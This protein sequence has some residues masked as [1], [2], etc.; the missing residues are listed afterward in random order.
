LIQVKL[1]R[2]I[3]TRTFQPLGST[4]TLNFKGK[5]V[6]ATHRNVHQAM[7][8]GEFRK[9]FYYRLCSDIITTPAL[10]QQTDLSTANLHRGP[11]NLH[12]T[13]SLPVV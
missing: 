2:V 7:A 4:Q 12:G 9:D 6:A 3:Q 8:Q 13:A 10:H 5:I 11:L 1:L